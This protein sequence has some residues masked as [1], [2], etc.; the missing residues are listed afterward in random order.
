MTQKLKFQKTLLL[1]A[2]CGILT[3]CQSQNE[4]TEM[5]E[6]TDIPV[7]QTEDEYRTAIAESGTDIKSLEEQKVYYETLLA[8]DCFTEDDYVSLAQ[9][10]GNLGEVDNQRS[11]LI[12]LHRLYPSLEH[13]QM[14]S[15]VIVYTD[16]TDEQV[17]SILR[18]ISETIENSNITAFSQ[19]IESDT[20]KTTMQDS[21]TG[22]TRKTSNQGETNFFI[23]SDEL[24][25][26]IQWD[27]ADGI[28]NCWCME[29]ENVMIVTAAVDD[30]G[31]QGIFSFEVYDL[32]GNQLQ[33]GSGTMKNSICVGEVHFW[34]NGVTYSGTCNEDGTTAEDQ[35]DE[36]L[37][38]QNVIYAYSEDASGYLYAQDTTVE[39]FRI[40]AEYLGLPA[41]MER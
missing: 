29:N 34:H 23:T 37:Q 13:A 31:F 24:R 16:D 3:A 27:N 33:G 39:D 12:K 22:V 4:S 38:N 41:E 35:I 5:S 2:L 28:R 18:Q 36:L 17:A 30:T 1:F 7:F 21:L 15:D 32:E 9:I 6:N 25:T 26:T 8:M 40:T 19:L 20:W 14:I 10:Y 11:I